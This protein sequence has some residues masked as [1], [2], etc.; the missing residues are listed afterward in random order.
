MRYV[1]LAWFLCG[2]SLHRLVEYRADFM[3]GLVGFLLRVGVQVALVH[4]IFSL[5]PS[6]HGWDYEQV[7]FLLGFAIL[8]RGMDKLFTDN[9][10]MVGG[11]LVRTGDLFRFMIRPV[12]PLF[13]VI[14]ERFF[15]PDA[16]GEILLGLVLV[17]YAGSRVGLGVPLA[18][19]A[20]TGP[21]LVL[22]GALVFTGVKLV[23]A[24][25]AFWTTTSHPVMHGAN[26]ISEF[27]G[28]PLE[29]YGPVL[30]RALVWV[31]PF[32]FTAYFPARYLLFG[33]RDEVLWSPV[34]A[35]AVLAV[36]LT[37]WSTGLRRYEMTGS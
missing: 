31:L 26:Q 29:L 5:V 30:R 35:A 22:C 36:G 4:I 28:Y 6:V 18:E 15:W 21:F 23:T 19:A 8:A 24:S 7:L 3:I 10:W 37:L 27:S 9:L 12:R 17:V 25:L 16:L 1:G 33:E 11:F 14:A 2:V 13:L 20:V 32:A 34:A